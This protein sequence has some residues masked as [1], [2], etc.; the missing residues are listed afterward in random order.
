MKDLKLNLCDLHVSDTL[1]WV[2]VHLCYKSIKRE[3]RED[4]YMIVGLFIMN[5][6]REI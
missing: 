2:S 6:E 4:Q 1:H 3:S 5:R